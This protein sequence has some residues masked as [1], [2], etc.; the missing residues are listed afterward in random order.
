M[1]VALLSARGM[2]EDQA[3]YLDDSGHMSGAGSLE[4]R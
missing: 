4:L 1:F 2:R 3:V